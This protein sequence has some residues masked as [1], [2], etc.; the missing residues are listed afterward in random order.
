MQCFSTVLPGPKLVLM[1]TDS[2]LAQDPKKKIPLATKGIR[3]GMDILY[4]QKGK[5]TSLVHHIHAELG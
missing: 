4:D 3:L 2:G 1:R 5:P